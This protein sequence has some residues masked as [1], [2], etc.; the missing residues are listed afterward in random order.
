MILHKYRKPYVRAGS[1]TSGYVYEIQYAS[2]LHEV[3]ASW[4][5]EY[6]IVC[7][8]ERGKGYYCCTE[9]DI[10]LLTHYNDELTHWWGVQ[11]DLRRRRHSAMMKQ[12][13]W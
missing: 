7:L 12:G 3:F 2:M 10:R 6:R 11:D 13:S 1:G 8:H 9:G 4:K 5:R